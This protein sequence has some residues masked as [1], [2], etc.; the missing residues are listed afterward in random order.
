VGYGTGNFAPSF[1]MR[2]HNLDVGQVGVILA[3]FGG[4]G[5]LVGTFLG[6][7]LADRLGQSDKRWYVWVPAIAG[8]LAIPLGFPYLLMDNTYIAIGVMFFA[9][10]AIST[11]LGPCVAISHAMV[12]PAMR[13]LAS[14]ILFFV[15]N[16]IGLGLGPVTV[17]LL[18]DWLTG[19]YGSD[20]L[21][22]AMLLVG[23]VGI[24]SI[25][26]FF[27]AGKHLRADMAKRAV[28]QD[29]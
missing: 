7:Y 13:A 6:G 21:R 3:I 27:M 23:I 9:T 29:A 16:L 18:S 8:T 15:I 2:S 26:M 1:L 5:G 4:G 22:Y 12:P 17:G 14:A 24:L 25:A 20:G 11:Y 19:I 10:M 28:L